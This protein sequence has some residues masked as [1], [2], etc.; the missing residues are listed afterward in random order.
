MYCHLKTRQWVDLQ[1]DLMSWVNLLKR[2][3]F[4][5][6][7]LFAM[8]NSLCK[9]QMQ[10]FKQ[11]DSIC[12]GVELLGWHW[13]SLNCLLAWLAWLSQTSVFTTCQPNW[14]IYMIGL[15]LPRKMFVQQ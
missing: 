9:I 8:A 15:F 13:G 4:L 5:P 6:K 2:M 7:L 3:I 10:V 11:L 14:Y 1:L 12:G